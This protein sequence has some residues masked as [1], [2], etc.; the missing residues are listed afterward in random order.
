[1]KVMGDWNTEGVGRT[2]GTRGVAVRPNRWIVDRAFAWLSRCWRMS[3]DYERNVQTSEMLSAE[4]I[5]LAMIRLFG[6]ACDGEPHEV[7]HGAFGESLDVRS[8]CPFSS[9]LAHVNGAYVSL[10]DL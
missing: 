10:G 6:P 1:M 7:L 5:A 4:L 2:P 9:S 3:K 8:P